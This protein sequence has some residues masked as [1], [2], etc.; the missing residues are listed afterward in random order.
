MRR[1][2]AGKKR[3]ANEASIIQALEA[4]GV[5]VWRVT[6]EG[7]PDLLCWFRGVWQPLEVKSA[8]GR[9]TEAQA[10]RFLETPF[11]I[12]RDVDQALA[13]FVRRR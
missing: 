4:V 6:G 5:K 10:K 2:G 9:L 7:L 11:P 13:H 3:D 8:G 1:G 12:V